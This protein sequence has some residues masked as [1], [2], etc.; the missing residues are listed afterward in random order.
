MISK[1]IQLRIK[2][3]GL[4]AGSLIRDSEKKHTPSTISIVNYNAEKCIF[5]EG[6]TLAEC[7]SFDTTEGIT[8][9]NIHGIEDPLLIEKIG[10][11]FELHPLLLEDIMTT[12]QRSKLDDYKEVIYI[13]VKMLTYNDQKQAVGDEQVSLI[14]GKNFV[15]SFLECSNGIFE[16]IKE[17]IKQQKS[18]IRQ[19]GSDYLCYAL[20]DSL[21]DNY[22]II[23][24][25]VDE[26]LENLE[27][28]LFDGRNFNILKE[29]QHTKREVILLRKCVW[30]MREVISHFRR[31]ESPLIQ[32]PTK[33]YIQDVYD[34]TIQAIDTIESFRDVTA[35]MLDIYLSNLSQRMNEV[36]KLLT[37]VAT[38]FVPLTFIASLYGMNFD[39]IPE[40]HN[41]YGYY[42]VL[43]TMLLISIAMLGCFKR[44]RWI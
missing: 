35:G 42:Y 27:D 43:G 5:K 9:I 10:R 32:D 23:L 38:I 2:K 16:P 8:W 24:E 3:I 31:L 40:L 1:S 25:K 37:I 19:R 13:V 36:M 26:T 11:R 21:V 18:R 12:G 15:I 4:Q 14:L 41:Y 28:R 29:I 7:L 34:H 22:F 30:P 6:I 17:R 44:K 39:N 33:L 20:I